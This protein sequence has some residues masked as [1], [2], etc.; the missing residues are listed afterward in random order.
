MLYEA[1]AAEVKPRSAERD[2]G[3][4]QDAGRCP[5]V[6]QPAGRLTVHVPRARTASEGVESTGRRC[7]A[8]GQGR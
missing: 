8:A 5:P 4:T 3:R 2:A 1:V 6:S 7:I